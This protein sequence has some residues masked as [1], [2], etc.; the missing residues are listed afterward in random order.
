MFCNC[1]GTCSS[2]RG[3]DGVESDAEKVFEDHGLNLRVCTKVQPR[4]ICPKC[5]G[6]SQEKGSF[7]TVG[8][9]SRHLASEHTT[10]FR[11]FT[12]DFWEQFQFK[13]FCEHCLHISDLDDCPGCGDQLVPVP[14]RKG[15]SMLTPAKGRSEDKRKFSKAQEKLD[16]VAEKL[17]FGGEKKTK[18]SRT[19][20]SSHVSLDATSLKNSQTFSDDKD[21]P[22]ICSNEPTAFH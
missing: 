18:R 22:L 11:D 15:D 7:V 13:K 9:M 16:E 4:F 5:I 10:N 20:K 6:D 1:G 21:G 14:D 8:E 17:A 3:D 2:C 12:G 19:S